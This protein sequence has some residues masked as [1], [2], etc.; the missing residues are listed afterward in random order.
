MKPFYYLYAL[1]LIIVLLANT[2]CTIINEELIILNGLATV[3]VI[4]N[5]PKFRLASGLE[6]CKWSGRVEVDDL[7]DGNHEVI[8]KC[9]LDLPQ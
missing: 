2:G 7:S 9:K 6:E 4:N 8:F 1:L 3:K 5:K